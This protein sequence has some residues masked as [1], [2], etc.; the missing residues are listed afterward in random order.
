M[1]NSISIVYIAIV[2]IALSACSNP[3]SGTLSED[4]QSTEFSPV[5]FT[6]AGNLVPDPKFEN[7]DAAHWAT[8][9]VVVEMALP[10]YPTILTNY[11]GYTTYKGS[12]LKS[13]VTSPS[14][15]YEWAISGKF[16]IDRNKAYEFCIWVY[17]EAADINNYLG[18]STYDGSGAKIDGIWVNPYFKTSEGDASSWQKWTGYIMPTETDANADGHPDIP[19][20]LGNAESE[21]AW[22]AQA[23]QAA[24]RFGGAYSSNSGAASYFSLPMVRQIDP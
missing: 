10:C 24:I 22:P 7:L 15:A 1:K 16:Q 6:L 23:A 3:D 2:V 13:T 8:I 12:V 14:S 20:G 9:P 18:F 19:I 17:S 4:D 11:G 5:D 21:W